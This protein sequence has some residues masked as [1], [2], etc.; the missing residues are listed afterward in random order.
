MN[1]NNK[2]QTLMTVTGQI[3]ATSKGYGFLR[4]SASERHFIAPPD[5]EKLLHGDTVEAKLMDNNGS[6]IAKPVRLVASNRHNLTGIIRRHKRSNFIE[7]CRSPSRRWME[8]DTSAHHTF[9]EEGD[10]VTVDVSIHPWDDPSH[11]GSAQLLDVLCKASNP[12]HPWRMVAEEFNVLPT[13]TLQSAE[14]ERAKEILNR[15]LREREDLTATPFVS[16]DSATTVDIDDLIH[17]EAIENGWNV[18]VAIADVSAFF[19][20]DHYVNSIYQEHGQSIYLPKLVSPM[21]CREYT[22]AFLSLNEGAD[23]L[24][25]VVSYSLDH[26]GR[27]VGE[28]SYKRA[29]VRN[30]CKLSYGEVEHC[31]TKHATTEG[32]P[33]SVSEHILTLRDAA[34]ASKSFRLTRSV[35]SDYSDIFFEIDTEGAVVDIKRSDR[36]SSHEIVEEFMTSTNELV[37]AFLHANDVKSY[38]T[39]FTGFNK[40]MV[41][42]LP[43][44][45]TQQFTNSDILGNNGYYN[46]MFSLKDKPALQKEVSDLCGG[47]E[48]TPTP[49]GHAARGVKAY[50]SFTSPIRKYRDMKA[51][52]QLCALIEGRVPS[53]VTRTEADNMDYRL[54]QLSH[55]KRNLMKHLFVSFAESNIGQV[56][57]GLLT[58]SIHKDKTD[59]LFYLVDPDMHITITDGLDTLSD[60]VVYEGIY[61]KLPIEITHINR[62]E[63]KVYGKVV[64]K[65]LAA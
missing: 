32:I 23:R 3:K 8:I 6:T 35:P 10:Y 18:S 41:G 44:R 42:R 57:S 2:E 1:K 43:S 30:H 15:E 19:G 46:V 58:F 62:R 4:V 45:V 24:A 13:H 40:S 11:Q 39:S 63:M 65:D 28:Q 56:K 16:I 52:Q 22:E 60:V 12:R 37:A 9:L 27:I 31:I 20:E 26:Q 38:F 33:S 55:A 25:A 61:N 54:K 64:P 51:H 14:F 59:M 21:I 7:F 48:I 17:V 5:M 53:A 49:L 34:N 50:C 47:S 29:V 36:L